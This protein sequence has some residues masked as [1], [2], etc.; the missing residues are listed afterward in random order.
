MPF[1]QSSI[2]CAGRQCRIQHS[3]RVAAADSSHANVFSFNLRVQ[4]ST[5]NQQVRA[6]QSDCDW[7]L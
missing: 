3:V 6:T 7:M 2:R 5:P 4:K 1:A